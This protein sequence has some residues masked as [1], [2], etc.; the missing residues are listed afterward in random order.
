MV[1]R[2]H[3]Y[4]QESSEIG[5]NFLIRHTEPSVQGSSYSHRDLTAGT[6]CWNCEQGPW[7]AVEQSLC[8]YQGRSSPE[9]PHRRGSTI[10]KLPSGKLYTFP[11]RRASKPMWSNL[12]IHTGTHS[13]ERKME[14]QKFSA[15]AWLPAFTT[16]RRQQAL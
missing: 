10:P 11:V 5:Q 14:I 9:K 1:V 8:T 6:D 15:M 16:A 13:L 2:A 4:V 7:P 3:P 12:S